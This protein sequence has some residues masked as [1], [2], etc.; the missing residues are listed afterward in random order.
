MT[1][2]HSTRSRKRHLEYE[3]GLKRFHEEAGGLFA[4]TSLIQGESLSCRRHG[5]GRFGVDSAATRNR[6]LRAVD[7]ARAAQPANSLPLLPTTHQ[8]DQPCDCVRRGDPGNT[9]ARHVIAF[10]FC[11]R[12][13]TGHPNLMAK[14]GEGLQR[15]FG[16]DLRPIRV[17]HPAGGCA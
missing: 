9:P 5:M 10:A 8:T 6:Q 7:P 1:T 2:A 13:S 11:D 12:C 16:P 14:A 3:A 15:I 4:W 17:T